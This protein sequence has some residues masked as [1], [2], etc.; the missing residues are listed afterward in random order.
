[1]PGPGTWSAGDVLTAA[2]L[3]DI[4][5]W[6]SYSPTLTQNGAR[7]ATITNAQYSQINKLCFVNFD[8]TCT[9]SGSAGSPITVSLPISAA[10]ASS[11]SEIRTIGSGFFYDASAT[12]VILLN[13][14]LVNSTNVGFNTELSTNP[15]VFF[16]NQ[17]SL[18]LANDDI[19]SASIVYQVA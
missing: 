17:P 11:G 12:D 14:G 3:N 9:T 5:V 18:A 6:Q 13:V 15:S 16:G 4:G 1:M 2:D 10:A 7:S 8:L 19:V